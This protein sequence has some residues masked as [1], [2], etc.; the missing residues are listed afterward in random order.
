MLLDITLP[1]EVSQL[2][3]E[4]LTYRWNPE[5][6]VP[7]NVIR[8]AVK[9]AKRLG[10]V[11]WVQELWSGTKYES[12]LL[13]AEE[14]TPEEKDVNEL[15]KKICSPEMKTSR[16]ETA[17]EENGGE[18]C[19]SEPTVVWH[20]DWCNRNVI[21]MDY[22]YIPYC[23][24]FDLW[25][26]EKLQQIEFAKMQQ[27]ELAK[28]KFNICDQCGDIMPRNGGKCTG[29]ECMVDDDDEDYDVQCQE[30]STWIPKYETNEKGYCLDCQNPEYDPV[31]PMGE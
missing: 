14:F 23:C 27:S 24:P 10:I 30:C 17:S 22:R 11:Q 5:R 9:S 6:E 13:T 18:A 2:S 8:A 19:E 29:F 12:F 28:K 20:S 15:A 16:F 7:D 26:K 3:N 21:H 1:F 31:W 4:E 25:H